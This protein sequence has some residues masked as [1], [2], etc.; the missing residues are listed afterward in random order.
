MDGWGLGFVLGI[1]V[2]CGVG[3]ILRNRVRVRLIALGNKLIDG[4]GS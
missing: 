1:K 2:G 4:I 3:I